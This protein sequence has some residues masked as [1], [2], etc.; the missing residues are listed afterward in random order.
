M[1]GLNLNLSNTTGT[2]TSTPQLKPWEIHEVVLKSIK[3]EELKGVKDPSAVY[4]VMK[5]RFEN[6]NGYFEPMIFAPKEGDE[7]RTLIEDKKT[8]NKKELVSSFEN[9]SFTIA[10]IGEQL[11][12]ESYSK[13]KKKAFSFPEEFKDFV[14][15]FAKAATSALN[16]KTKIKLIGDKKN[17]PRLPYF[18][19]LNK[20]GEAF[21]TGNF[22]G[23][24]VFFTSY[25][26][27]SAEKAANAKPTNMDK[28][29]STSENTSENKDL[30]TIDYNL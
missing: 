25:E 16:K 28:K 21:V 23:E 3:Y 19:A 13:L 26:L 6:E 1:A 4:N 7:V 5:I 24:K 2:S 30:D 27:E 15:L 22:I 29:T 8:G 17:K 18:V 10:Q 9:F 11:F 12:P 20:D 14:E